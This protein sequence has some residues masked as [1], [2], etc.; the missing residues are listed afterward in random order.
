MRN[1]TPRK[2]Q[3]SWRV[4]Y[5]LI[6]KYH[7]NLSSGEQSAVIAQLWQARDEY[8]DL[9]FAVPE[10][11]DHLISIWQAI[12]KGTR[13][14]AKLGADYNSSKKGHNA[15]IHERI[16]AGFKECTTVGVEKRTEIL[17]NLNLSH[18]ILLSHDVVALVKK[19][20]SPQLFNALN[21]IDFLRESLVKSVTKVVSDIAI[22]F[23]NNNIMNSVSF[24]Y[25]DLFQQGMLAVYDAT[26]LYSAN[27]LHSDKPATW[28]TF[29]FSWVLKKITVYVAENSRLISIP[30]YIIE[31]WSVV[32]K[33]I[34]ICG[35]D[36]SYD[37]CAAANRI[38]PDTF[39][40][41]T[42][43]EIDSLMLLV[44]TYPLD[45]YYVEH[46]LALKD[47]IK[48]EESL[49]NKIND[50]EA[51]HKIHEALSIL[52]PVERSIIAFRWGLE[53][54][55]PLSFE[56]TSLKIKERHNISISKEKVLELD[57]EARTKLKSNT[58][59]KI[60]WEG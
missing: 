25:D 10:V 50:V 45:L 47:T 9:L 26:M 43:L 24:S 5:R 30:R 51:I 18:R 33:A 40:P 39:N 38:R 44:N 48:D 27:N 34:E 52:S 14:V 21:R 13:T 4:A 17:R 28:F 22:K 57:A 31:R 12:P 15:K 41:F 46:G 36:A 1:N 56:Q 49:E 11:Q 59:L 7:K 58:N 16:N 42:P 2:H 60:L 29:A 54:G 6:S 8:Y 53:N 20:H 32:T 23:A 35:S 37:V 55:V 19:G 3:S